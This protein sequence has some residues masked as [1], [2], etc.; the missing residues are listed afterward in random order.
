M[1]PVSSCL[2]NADP[3]LAH[4]VRIA[5]ITDEIQDVAT[6]R[7]EFEDSAVADAYSFLPGQFNMLYLPGVGEA[8]ISISSDPRQRGVLDHTVRV[9]GS[10]TGELAQL[11]EGATFG[12][13]GPFGSAWPID[14]CLGGDVVIVTGGIG[15]APLRPAI[16]ELLNRK[17]E[18]G[19]LTLLYGAREPSGLL[20]TNEFDDWRQRGFEVAVTVDRGTDAW[21]GNVGV[22]PQLLD[23]MPLEHPEQTTVLC[24]GPEVMMWFAA[25]SALG[26]GVPA[27]RIW[28]SLERNMNCA[29]G[30][31]GHCQ[32]G[33]SFICKDGPVLRYDLVAPLLR[34]EGF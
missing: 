24:C 34:V 16:Y 23:R 31:C 18:C 29:I 5:S 25:R 6:Y 13:R 14:E 11:Q 26:R 32:F 20:Y 28:V 33:P 21:K 2:P 30:L 27:E 15:L 7:L 3:W 10:V 19:Q 8:A 9:A 1:N 17:D 22:V 4:T 12:L